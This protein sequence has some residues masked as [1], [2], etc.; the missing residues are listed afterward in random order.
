VDGFEGWCKR[1]FGKRSADV[2]K[3]RVLSHDN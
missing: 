1:L 2:S 3:L